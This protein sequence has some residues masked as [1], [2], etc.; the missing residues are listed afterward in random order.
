MSYLKKPLIGNALFVM[1]VLI[2][3][4]AVQNTYYLQIMTFIGINTL[5]ALGLNMLMGYAGQVSLGH[6][7][8]YGIGAYTT[9]ILSGT[10]AISPWAGLLCAVV[11]AVLVAFIVGLPTLKLSGYYLGMG[12]LGFGMIVNIIFR[13][14]S[15][16]TGGSSGFVGIPMLELGPI[17]F[18]SGKNY[19]F[20]VW[21]V[22]F[23]AIVLCQRILSSRMGR[24]LRSIHDGENASM[25]VGV[26]THFLKLQIFM[27]SAALGAVAG[28][29]YAHFVLFISPE[30]F[31]FMV[32]IKMVTMVVIGGMASVWGALFG[33]SL[34]TLLPEVLHAFAEY[35]MIVF[36]LILMLVMIFM[37]QGLTRGL[38]DIYERSKREKKTH[39]RVI[40]PLNASQ[41]LQQIK[42]SQ[43]NSQSGKELPE[44]FVQ[45]SLTAPEEI[46]KVSSLTKMFGGVK[47]Q[48]NISFSIEKGIVCGLIGP[49]GA[50][51]TTLFNLIT[52]IYSP[53]A[54]EVLF[55][56]KNTKKYAVHQL[57]REGIARTFQ[58]VELFG[59]MTL[60]E[61][62][63]VGMHVRTRSGFW[64]AITRMPWVIREEKRSR[65]KACEIIEFT[66][67]SQYT[68][69]PAGDLP[70]G[71]QKMAEIAR[72][73][74]SEPSLLL[75]DEPAA[76]LNAVET[77]ALG[78]LINK[79]RQKGIT[80]MLVEHDMSLAM[81][82]SDKVIVL[83]RGRKLAEGSPREIQNNQDVMD[84]YLGRG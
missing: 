57:V 83:D 74:A 55:K 15:S 64:G 5:L 19:F 67:L 76:G 12:T 45:G 54:G 82:I 4:L 52:G 29:L 6:A 40:V 50:G 46:L 68:H 21:F 24:A 60:L 30:S 79:V 17:S 75:L 84:A 34:L 71:R 42:V 22:V 44:N 63:L 11:G 33:A 56:G 43:G 28:F 18:V 49:N 41:D 16:F 2:C 77:E 72:A 25:A 51:K 70:I 53:D 20:L 58:H 39:G 26:N 9:A 31:G 14:W 35:E 8:F 48:D 66:G 81:G 23:I 80:M 1:A 36:G 7:A 62:V 27:F 73:L 10:F 59:S 13:E 61:N 38:I 32:S 47:A 3:G 69:R 78:N 65:E 37:P